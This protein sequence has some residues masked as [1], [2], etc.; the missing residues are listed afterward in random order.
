MLVSQPSVSIETETTQRTPSPRRPGLPTVFMTSRKS[1]ASDTASAAAPAPSCAA[2]SRALQG[3]D[4]GNPQP[5][6]LVVLGRLILLFAPERFFALARRA[7]AIA[8]VRLVVDDDDILQ[9]QKL[10]A[11]ALQHRALGLGRDRGLA[12]TLQQARGRLWRPP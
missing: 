1:S 6:R 3:F 4:A 11:G 2:F 5:R 7:L 12:A 9:G 10:A 8:V